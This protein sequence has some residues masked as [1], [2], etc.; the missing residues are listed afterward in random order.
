MQIYITYDLTLNF[1]LIMF[2][3]FLCTKFT[4]ANIYDFEIHTLKT[5]VQ[6]DLLYTY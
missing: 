2:G 6:L 4:H 5:A 3:G 1:K